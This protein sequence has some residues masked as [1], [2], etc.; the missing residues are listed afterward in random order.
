MHALI[1]CEYTARGGIWF[2]EANANKRSTNRCS[3][4]NGT[5]APRRFDCDRE[6]VLL[7]VDLSAKNKTL[8]RRNSDS[9]LAAVFQVL[10]QMAG[11]TICWGRARMAVRLHILDVVR[12]QDEFERVDGYTGR[13]GGALPRRVVLA[14]L[15]FWAG[16]AELSRPYSL[17][18]VGFRGDYRTSV[19]DH[20]VCRTDHPSRMDTYMRPMAPHTNPSFETLQCTAKHFPLV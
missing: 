17:C 20:H 15:L 10:S 19:T 9:M 14:T 11:D 12:L 7:V 1:K 8:A 6:T 18:T 13:L 5:I 4:C 16:D 3:V 2:G